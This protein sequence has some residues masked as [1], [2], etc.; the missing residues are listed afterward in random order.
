M[1]SPLAVA[2]MMMMK[3]LTRL[4]ILRLSLAAILMLLGL[5]VLL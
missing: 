4:S 5:V 2:M 3:E 1:P